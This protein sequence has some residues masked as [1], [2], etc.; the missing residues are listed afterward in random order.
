MPVTRAPVTVA[1]TTTTTL[2]PGPRAPVVSRVAVHAPVVFITIDDGY[3][4]DPRVLALVKLLHLP[5]TA[6]V[7]RGPAL[8]GL[9]YWRALQAAGARIEDHTITHPH[10][11]QLDL[12]DQEHE[13]CGP[14][15]EFATWFGTRPTLFR[16]PYG[17]Y[18]EATRYAAATCGIHAVVLWRATLSDGKLAAQGGR[19]QPGDIILMHWRPTL[20]DDLVHLLAL[21][22]AQHLGVGQ[23]EGALAAA[24]D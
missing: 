10:L 7:I 15:D 16:P 3:T 12:A 1:S 14:L 17:D 19:L 21:L 22:R 6:F 23:L 5:I 4:R 13:I 9:A 18:D 8:A 24:G 11:Q 2:P 20:Y